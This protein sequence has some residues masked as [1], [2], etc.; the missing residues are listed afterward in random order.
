MNKNG[1]SKK[2]EDVFIDALKQICKRVAGDENKKVTF[3]VESFDK[4]VL[5][6]GHRRAIK[7]ILTQLVRNAVFHGIETPEERKALGKDE[8][9]KI[10]LN[11]KAENGVIR[12]ILAD[13]GQGLDFD[14]IAQKAT[15]KGLLKNPDTDK[16]NKQILSNIIFNTGFSTSEKED[17]HGG[18]GIG[19]NLVRDSL[20]EIQ[21]N[22]HL[23]SQKGHGL[24][25]EI[26]IPYKESN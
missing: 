19:L 8:E 14:R 5:A 12:L 13:D 2:E 17:L 4:K 16:N 23:N 10:T 21:G 20:K 24:T 3:R 6:R 7:E 22:I 26:T 11:I 1:K 18:R 15:E 9:G 25:F